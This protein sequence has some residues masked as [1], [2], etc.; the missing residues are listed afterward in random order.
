MKTKRLMELSKK[1][2][3]VELRQREKSQLSEGDDTQDEY[4]CENRN[5]D[6]LQESYLG[7]PTIARLGSALFLR[8]NAKK[9]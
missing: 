8:V 9:K 3:V 2:T 1:N 4:E 7:S 6:G 5:E